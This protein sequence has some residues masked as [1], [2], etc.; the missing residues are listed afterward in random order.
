MNEI[1]RLLH[2]CLFTP[3][4]NGRWGL[5]ILFWGQPGVGKSKVIEGKSDELG[6]MC[7]TLIASIR[8]PSDFG[9]LP[10]PVRKG[11]QYFIE[12]TPAG[13]AADLAIEGDGRGVV[14]LDEVTTCAPATQAALLRL[15]LNG[16][17]GDYQL[18]PGV[19]FL[20]AANEVADAAGGW[21]LS[22]PLA[23]RL[24]HCSWPTPDGETWTAWLVGTNIAGDF[25]ELL[26]QVDPPQATTPRTFDPA[27]EEKRVEERWPEAFAKAKGM[28]SAFVRA[29]RHLL[30][31]M[32]KAGQ[33]SRSKAWPSPRSWEYATRALGGCFVHEADETLSME[34]ISAFVGPAAATEF[35][36]FRKD[37]DLPDPAGL[38]DGQLKFRHDPVRLDRTNAVLSSCTALLMA[39]KCKRHK[40]RSLKLWEIISDIADVGTDLVI[41]AATVLMKNRWGVHTKLYEGVLKKMAPALEAANYRGR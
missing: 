6:L 12:Y 10:I 22:A 29:Q 20:A 41:P 2:I 38:L 3:G 28:I 17:L 40:E 15:I 30:H 32:P 13:W 11:N 7:H 23:N 1:E 19:R 24:G 9:G 25:A 27:E 36:A 35:V 4:L 31:A 21:D 39:P 18:P 33:E 8:E 34:L 16:A 5:P 26:G 37:L 14:F